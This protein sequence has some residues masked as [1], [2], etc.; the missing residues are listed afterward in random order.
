MLVMLL[1]VAVLMPHPIAQTEAV[2]VSD[3]RI[4]G[5]E[6]AEFTS[7]R[8][9]D[10]VTATLNADQY[11]LVITSPRGISRL[12]I[13]RVA[14]HWPRQVLIQ[15]Q[16]SGLE[17]LKLTTDNVRLEAAVSSHDGKV[18]IWESDREEFPLDSTDAYWF[19]ISR[20][21]AI[22]SSP[23]SLPQPPTRPGFE[24][25]LPAKLLESN[26]QVITLAW[27]DFYR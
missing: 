4:K 3:N 16:L 19:K 22:A 20:H 9:D 24:F 5:D 7:Q 12:T 8:A 26:P 1:A 21:D 6:V 13:K 2:P 27:I 14:E 17:S 11:R 25:S 10:V 15:L 18:R 23:E